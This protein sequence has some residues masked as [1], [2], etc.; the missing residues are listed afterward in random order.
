[1]ASLDK[2]FQLSN[3]QQQT[4]GLGSSL[5]AV[6]KMMLNAKEIQANLIKSYAAHKSCQ[7]QAKLIKCEAHLKGHMPRP[8]WIKAVVEVKI[9]NKK[10]EGGFSG[11]VYVLARNDATK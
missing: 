8:Q 3:D 5:S 2:T 7:K 1:M 11:L 4:I 9:L 10:Y 6:R